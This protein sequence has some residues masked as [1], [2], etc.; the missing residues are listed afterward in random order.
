MSKGRGSAS[1]NMLT[2]MI[3]LLLLLFLFE[4]VNGATYNVGGPGGWTYN[5][6]TWPNGKKFRAGDVLSKFKFTLSFSHIYR[7]KLC[8]SI[9]IIHMHMVIGCCS[10]QLRFNDTQCC[11]CGPRWI[12][13]LQGI[14]RC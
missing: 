9:L 4:S 11:C 7:Y 1:M 6:D 2:V 3:S 5:T 10:F 8:R 13:E 14:R 12:W